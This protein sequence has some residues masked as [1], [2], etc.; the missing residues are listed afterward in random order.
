MAD[1]GSLIQPFIYLQI[2][3]QV[4]GVDNLFSSQHLTQLILFCIFFV[5][6]C[7][8]ICFSY[9][10]ALRE[11]TISTLSVIISVGLSRMWYTKQMVK[12]LL[13]EWIWPFIDYLPQS[14]C[15]FI[16]RYFPIS[17]DT[18]HI[19]STKAVHN[20][21]PFRTISSSLLQSSKNYMEISH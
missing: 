20:C 18:F 19:F 13:N 14:A 11:G 4:T 8:C 16:T 10:Q 15:H 17:Q 7:T 9:R 6:V 2:L 5:C 3:T 21:F 1:T 12:Y